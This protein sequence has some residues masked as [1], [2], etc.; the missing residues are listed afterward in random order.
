MSDV[1]P[2]APPDEAPPLD[3]AALR[4]ALAL[5]GG[6][7]AE[8]GAVMAFTV[9]VGAIGAAEPMILRHVVDGLGPGQPTR[10]LAVG[11]GGLLVIAVLRELVGAVTSWMSWRARLR[12]HH[13]LLRTATERLHD[14]SIAYHRKEPVGSLVTKLDRG[15]QGVVAAFAELAFHV[16]PAVAFL[17][18]AAVMMVKLHWQ[19]SLAIF[20]VIP[21]PALIGV[22]AAPRQAQRDRRLMDRWTHIYGRFTEVMGAMLTVKSFAMERE[23]QRRFLGRVEEANLLVIGGVGFDARVTAAQN[24]L[25]A[26]GRVAVIGWGGTLVLQG[27][28]TVGTLLAFLAYLAG[29]F[30]PVQGLTSA[31]QTVR[32]AAVA[33]HAYFSIANAIEDVPDQP[34]AATLGSVRGDVEF[35]GVC[36]EYHHGVPVLDDVSVQIRAGETVALVGGS[37]GGKTTLAVLLQRLYDPQRGIIRVDGMDVRSFTQRSLRQQI[38]VVLQDAVLFK[39][40]V[41]ANIAYGRPD[42]TLAEVEAA[43]R[44]AHA[45]DFIQ[46]LPAGY[47]TDVGERGGLLSAGQRQR[48]AIARALLKNPS[49]VILDEATSA[50]DAESE[51]LVEAALTRL[52]HGR[53]TL[54]IAHR[55]ATVVRADR[56]LVLRGGRI[57]EAGT[58]H[59][60][61]ARGGHYASLVFQQ[62]RGL[63]DGTP[64]LPA[65][66]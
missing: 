25:G 7:R 17:L 58:H 65:A 31:Y 35:D 47:D 53:T 63:I 11:V 3:F 30:G 37:G 23:E 5:A 26:L 46:A 32:R 6:R 48:L 28:M 14:L 16:I 15:I 50:L 39:D 60:L 57:V 56:I 20:L 29:L 21:L 62:T 52:L 44:A 4:R 18:F 33:L 59:E 9:S 10:Q 64:T 55:L 40:S 41:R 22:W 36:F 13:G 27:R 19:L 8:V 12:M 38:G 45:H 2:P 1:S 54:V 34:G 61:V 24:L 49:I 43:A 66:A 42:A 51:A